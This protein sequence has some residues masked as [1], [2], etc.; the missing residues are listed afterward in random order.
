VAG[1]LMIMLA[2]KVLCLNAIYEA[3]AA[4]RHD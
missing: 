1:L 3:K 2:A 4:L